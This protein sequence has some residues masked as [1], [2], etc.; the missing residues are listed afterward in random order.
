MT[1]HADG[2]DG[3]CAVWLAADAPSCRPYP[4]RCAST[5]DDAPDWAR[6]QGQARCWWRKKGLEDTP[7]GGYRSRCPCW[8]G[9]RDGKPGDCCAHHSANP[10][11][12]VTASKAMAALEAAAEPAADDATQDLG[13]AVDPVDMDE[14]PGNPDDPF[15]PAWGWETWP[16]E[17]RKP[18]VRR[19][20]TEA[21][22]CE[23]VLP[24]ANDKRAATVH[25]VACHTDWANP[26][27]FSVHRRRWTEP[28]RDPWKVRDCDTGDPLLY[29]DVEGIWRDRYPSAA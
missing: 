15:D 6:K 7:G 19:W 17:E 27:T 4:C 21:L 11:Y 3:T 16:E 23:C 24:Y 8:G 12:L 2:C 20:P 10:Y 26:Q 14:P 29:Q 9:P 18:F 13:D 5:R 28:C 22:T 1:E 25:C